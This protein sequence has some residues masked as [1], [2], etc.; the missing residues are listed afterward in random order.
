MKTRCPSGLAAKNAS[1]IA[2]ASCVLIPALMGCDAFVSGDYQGDPLLTLEG[3]ILVAEASS[4]EGEVP[5]RVSMFWVAADLSE[6][7]D[8]EVVGEQ[9]VGAR[10]AQPARY[11]LDI[12][13]PPSSRAVTKTSNGDMAIA[14]ILVYEDLNGNGRREATERALGGS[15]EFAVLYAPSG[16]DAGAF[17]VPLAAG[18]H[19]ME[20]AGGGECDD[21]DEVITMEPAGEDRWVD[22][23]IDSEGSVLLPDIDCDGRHEFDDDDDDDDNQNGQQ[24]NN[25]NDDDDE[26]G[27]SDE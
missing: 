27:Q 20:V 22:L 14:V 21:D 2:L 5:L 7:D 12:Y 17:G 16:L 23:L 10:A 4:L 9:T 25:G 15:G 26:D 19:V 8:L 24:D 18:Y 13:H 3:N 6:L 1:R 11:T